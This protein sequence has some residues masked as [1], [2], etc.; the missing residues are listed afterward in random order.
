[1]RFNVEQI[2]LDRARRDAEPA[3]SAVR[4]HVVEGDTIDAAL[5]SFLANHAAELVGPPKTFPGLQALA[6]ARAKDSVFTLHLTP[7]SDRLPH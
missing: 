2:F 7:S 4:Y 1:M 5:A 6:T 3:P